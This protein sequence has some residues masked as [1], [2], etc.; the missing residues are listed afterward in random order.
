[1][2]DAGQFRTA[3]QRQSRLGGNASDGIER[4]RTGVGWPRTELNRRHTDFQSAA[5]PTELL[6]RA[7]ALRK[8]TE[9]R[10]KGARIIRAIR[11]LAK[12]SPAT[13]C[14]GRFLFYCVTKRVGG[15]KSPP[16]GRAQRAH[17]VA[18]RAT[19]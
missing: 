12:N 9:T 14:A 10:G 5:L 18:E 19:P 16:R 13:M 3:F 15:K 7:G 2:D 4:R 17:W 1:M 6:G 11:L 8:K